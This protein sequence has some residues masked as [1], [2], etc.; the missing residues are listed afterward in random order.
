M[1]PLDHR[2]RRVKNISVVDRAAHL[3]R[4]GLMSSDILN[5]ADESTGGKV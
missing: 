3:W 4:D 1:I 5:E 2:S